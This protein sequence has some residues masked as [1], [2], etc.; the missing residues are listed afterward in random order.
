MR[1]FKTLK[2]FMKSTGKSIVEMDKVLD[3]RIWFKNGHKVEDFWLAD[4]ALKEVANLLADCWSKGYR[5]RVVE[6]VMSKHGDNSYLQCFHLE[7]SKDG[8]FRVG[9]SLSGDAYDY[10]KRKWL[11]S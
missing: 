2:G 11:K 1:R 3:G 9:N 10:C 4:S 8:T 6:K 7:T 5:K